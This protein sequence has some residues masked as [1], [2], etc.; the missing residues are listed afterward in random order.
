MAIPSTIVE[1]DNYSL[2]DTSRLL[3]QF[4]NRHYGYVVTPNVDHL[5]RI[6]EDDE[7][8]SLYQEATYSFLDSKF[9]SILLKAF[10]NIDLNVCRGSDLTKHLFEHVIEGDD[11]IVVIGASPAQ[12]AHVKKQYGLKNVSHF[13]PPMGFINQPADVEACLKY[14]EELSPFRFC[15]LAVGSPQQE[16][17]ANRLGERK[18][19]LGLALCVGASID[20]LTGKEMRA[21]EYFQRWGL[22][23]LF[24]LCANPARL[25][26]RYLIRGPKFFLLLR[27]LKISSREKPSGDKNKS[28]PP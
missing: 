3:E 1:I 22:E 15:F 28:F 8:K 27:D 11:H 2:E 14:V 10:R 9:A 13:E 26:H 25:Y 7:F 4:D 20:F 24:R 21:P 6:S 16:I 17:I 23:W 5:I 12:I 19:T 18:R